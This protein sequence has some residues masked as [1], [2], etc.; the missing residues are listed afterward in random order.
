MPSLDKELNFRFQEGV[1]NLIWRQWSSLGV[2]GATR[3]ED[4]WMVDPE[5]L[6]LLTCTAG[7]RDARVFDEVLDW[8]YQFG[9][10]INTQRLTRMSRNYGFQG[11]KVLSAVAA[12]MRTRDKT[13]KWKKLA[14]NPVKGELEPLF[15]LRDGKPIPVM[16]EPDESFASRGFAR[17]AM[18][19]R[20]YSQKFRPVEPATLLLQCRALFGL[21]ARA[22]V[23]AWLLT[24]GEG[25]PSGIAR[26]CGY[27]QRA[28]QNALVEMAGS[29]VV[30]VKSVGKEKRYWTDHSAWTPLLDRENRMPEWVDWAPLFRALERMWIGMGDWSNSEETKPLVRS[31][32]MREVFREVEPWLEQSGFH[33][34]F[35]D[36]RRYLGE[37]Y[38]EVFVQDVE[39]LLGGGA[40]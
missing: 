14:G 15:W 19:L 40:E 39:R 35:S 11:E 16:R 21:N 23:M 8:L 9:D 12:W 13:P 22:E 33:Q 26:A 3:V 25:H 24:H 34:T 6:L 10:M 20:G 28:V 30:R 2:A 32:K 36:P 31:S 1:L 37:R 38:I 17:D 7:R 27:S 4:R 18:H 29:G 5:A